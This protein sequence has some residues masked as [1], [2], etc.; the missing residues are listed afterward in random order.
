[1]RR[2]LTKN[3][4]GCLWADHSADTTSRTEVQTLIDHNWMIATA[5]IVV[6][7]SY[8]L[9]G[10]GVDTE[11]TSFA[12]FGKNGDCASD[13]DV[14]LSIAHHRLYVLHDSAVA[15]VRAARI[16]PVL[17]EW[18][19]EKPWHYT[20]QGSLPRLLY[21]VMTISNVSVANAQQAIKFSGC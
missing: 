6:R 18:Q 12:P 7:Y 19:Q 5:V 8:H 13:H 14:S 9:P 21:S 11:F 20:C 15:M 1:M 17:L 2:P 16:T 10:A 4:K 3:R